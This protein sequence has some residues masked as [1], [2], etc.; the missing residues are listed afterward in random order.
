MKLKHKHII[1]LVL[2]LAVS[3]IMTACG[4]GSSSTNRICQFDGCTR[5]ATSSA[6]EFCSYHEKMLNDYWDASRAAGN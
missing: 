2:I 1:M 5:K 3:T 4:S 6:G